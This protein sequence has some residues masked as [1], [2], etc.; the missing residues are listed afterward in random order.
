MLLQPNSLT[1]YSIAVSASDDDGVAVVGNHAI[2]FSSKA[3][4][5]LRDYKFR[6]AASPPCLVL[7][8]FCAVL[9]VAIKASQRTITALTFKVQP[10]IADN[11]EIMISLFECQRKKI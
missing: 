10:Q 6:V 11:I 8:R 1:L 3:I 2:P 9:Q 4:I 7:P 5:L